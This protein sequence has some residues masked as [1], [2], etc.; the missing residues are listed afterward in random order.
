MNL[1]SCLTKH[2]STLMRVLPSSLHGKLLK[3]Y[4][5]D[6]EL[7]L[8]HGKI[9]VNQ[10]WSSPVTVK[11]EIDVSKLGEKRHLPG[12]TFDI[13]SIHE[14]G[15]NLGKYSLEFPWKSENSSSPEVPWGFMFPTLD[16]LVLYSMIRHFKPSRYIE[17]GC[18]YSSRVSSAACEK[19]RDEGTATRTQYIEPYPGERLEKDNLCGELIVKR[20]QEIPLEFFAALEPGDILFIDTSHIMKCQSDVEWELLHVLPSL[21]KGVIV[22][23]HDI[24][25]PYEYPAEWLDNNYAPGH[26]N[27]QYAFEALLSGGLRFRTIF[28]NHYLCRENPESINKWFGIANDLSRSY[29]MIVD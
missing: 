27:E 24:Y 8:A 12:I 7:T 22:H 4:E 28:P 26:Y 15:I 19:N 14:L 5:R 13:D 17:V 10:D 11:S 6:R 2:T 25:T 20:I 29:W 9:C 18:G 1:K 23:I 16:S 3:L 21:R